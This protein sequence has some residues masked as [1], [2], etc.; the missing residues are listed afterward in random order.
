[1]VNRDSFEHDREMVIPDDDS[2]DISSVPRDN[3]QPNMSSNDISSV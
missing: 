3:S 2:F 1:V